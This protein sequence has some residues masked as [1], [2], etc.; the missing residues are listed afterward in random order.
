MEERVGELEREQARQ[1]AELRHMRQDLEGVG[2]SVDGVA[3]DVK[4][5][6]QREAGRKEP[7]SL[8]AV[9]K[10]VAT[11]LGLAAGCWYL[12]GGVVEH[13]PAVV[14]LKERMDHAEW[15]HGWAARITADKE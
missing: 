5:L 15:K 4:T 6:L 10:T 8:P 3:M 14:Q 13:S 12:I 1:G 7:M 9:V 11:T 2:K